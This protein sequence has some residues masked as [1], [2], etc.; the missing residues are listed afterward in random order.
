MDD[1]SKS[2]NPEWSELPLDLVRPLLRKMNLADM[3]R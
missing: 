3:E 1:R 2:G